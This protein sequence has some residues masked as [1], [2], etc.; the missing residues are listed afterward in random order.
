LAP[1][2]VLAVL[3]WMVEMLDGITGVL[4]MQ[5]DGY[6]SELN[7]LVR[8]AFQDHGPLA[9]VLLLKVGPST[10]VLLA[11]LRLARKRPVLAR[12]VL[13]AALALGAIGVWSNL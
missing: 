3:A 13:L 8:G 5:R 12:N 6:T 10:L 11:F 9:V 7:P 4:M 2:V 1:L